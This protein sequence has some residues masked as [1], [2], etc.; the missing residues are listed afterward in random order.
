MKD[1]F[2]NAPKIIKESQKSPLGIVAMVIM[3][4]SVV[5]LCFFRDAHVAVKVL[6]FFMI[7]GAFL[8]LCLTVLLNHYPNEST[9]KNPDL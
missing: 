3:A 1:L 6:I 9:P 8:A 7:T 5:A 4:I 2:S